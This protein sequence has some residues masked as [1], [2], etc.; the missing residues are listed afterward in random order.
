MT[1]PLRDDSYGAQQLG[2]GSRR[3]AEGVVEEQTR[4]LRAAW[5]ST[6]SRIDQNR[7]ARARARRPG[8]PV[9]VW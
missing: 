4:W 7:L 3:G 9:A 1:R 5:G 2:P 6:K 8:A